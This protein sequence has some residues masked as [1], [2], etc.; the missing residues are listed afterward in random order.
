MKLPWSKPAPEPTT[1][2]EPAPAVIDN[3]VRSATDKKGTATP[4]RRDAQPRRS[5]P[6]QAPPMTG[7]EARARM[8]ERNK[9][10]RA[11]GLKPERRP[12]A[13]AAEDRMTARDAG[14]ERALVRNIVDSR[15]SLG[16]VFPLFA[17]AVLVVTFTGLQARDPQLYNIVSLIWLV[18]FVAIIAESIWLSRKVMQRIRQDFPKTKERPGSL[19]FYAIMRSLMFRRGRYPKPIVNVG[20][21]V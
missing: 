12:A 21:K 6:V 4:K 17:I 9:E 16:S 8:K 15:R 10:R 3:P 7:K 13:A 14:P 18:F 11:Q 1:Q 19:R 2:P 20:D 5:G